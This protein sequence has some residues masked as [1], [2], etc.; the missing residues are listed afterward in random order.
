MLKYGLRSAV[1]TVT[2]M[3]ASVS[4][5][6]VR[7]LSMS[8]VARRGDVGGMLVNAC[9]GERSPAARSVRIACC[10]ADHSGVSSWANSGGRMNGTSAPAAL[11]TSAMRSSSV[12]TKT[13]SINL[14]RRADSMECV[15]RA[16]PL[17]SR[18]FFLLM[19]LDPPRANT[20]ATA[21]AVVN[22]TP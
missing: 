10:H 22:V 21:G 20:I 14:L 2:T 3:S 13:R 4:M 17:S 16:F 7:H 9:V 8:S 11:A 19:P 6:V 18:R 15:M 5:S 1:R 12:E